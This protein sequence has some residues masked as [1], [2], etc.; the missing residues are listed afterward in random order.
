MIRGTTAQFK[1]QLPYKVDDITMATIRF[2]QPGNNNFTPII[3]TKSNCE[4]S[5][6][7]PMELCV[8]LNP[9][10]TQQFSTKYKGR[11]QLIAQCGGTVFG[12]RPKLFTVYPMDDE[13]I[14]DFPELPAT[15]QDNWVIFDGG[16][17]SGI[18]GGDNN[19]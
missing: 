16:T 11:V 7:D 10:D 15:T 8:S 12:S 17:V 18:A 5:A 6:D 13:M 9:S 14:G 4:A 2:W 1:F 19:G 3:R